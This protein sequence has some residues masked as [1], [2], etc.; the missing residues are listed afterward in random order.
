[1]HIVEI[2]KS[3]Q[4]ICERMG[5][6]DATVCSMQNTWTEGRKEAIKHRSDL[7][8]KVEAVASDVSEL[9][10]HVERFKA[11]RQKIVRWSYV[12]LLGALGINAN[13]LGDTIHKVIGL[14][15]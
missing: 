13:T 2:N 14:V 12:A 4:K 1:M 9:K 10:P 11:D 5:S 8:Q 15:K 3:L 7:T 6:L